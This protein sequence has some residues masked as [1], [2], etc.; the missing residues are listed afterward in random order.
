MLVSFMMVLVLLDVLSPGGL[1]LLDEELILSETLM[2]IVQ[3]TSVYE[4]VQSGELISSLSLI[5]SELSAM[6]NSE[7][8]VKMRLESVF[9]NI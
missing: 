3:I 2:A 9:V 1:T 6:F 8:R 5:A 4:L 7:V